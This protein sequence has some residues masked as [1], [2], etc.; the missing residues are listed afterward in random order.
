MTAGADAVCLGIDTATPYLVV[1]VWSRAAG[2]LA[3]SAERVERGHSRLLIPTLEAALGEAGVA[4]SAIGALA[5]GNGPGSYT[6]LRVGAA[7]VRGL[8]RALG[9]PLRGC[10]TLAAMAYGALADGQEGVAMLDARRGNVYAGRYRREVDELLTLAA[11]QKL[12]RGEATASP[13]G[14]LLIEDVPP[15]PTYLAR[16]ALSETALSPIYL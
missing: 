5:A 4:R 10:D 16:C 6:G 15:D 3:A 12:S 9:V 1:A 11:P 8:A 14:V 7:A 13:A 2:L